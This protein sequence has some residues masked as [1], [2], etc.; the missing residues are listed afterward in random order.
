VLLTGLGAQREHHARS[1][2]LHLRRVP[3]LGRPRR[4]SSIHSSQPLS[5]DG[6]LR[7][8]VGGSE[9]SDLARRHGSGGWHWHIQ[10]DDRCESK[11]TGRDWTGNAS[12]TRGGR[13]TCRTTLT[14]LTFSGALATTERSPVSRCCTNMVT[15]SSRSTGCGVFRSVSPVRHGT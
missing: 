11:C 2:L 9:R 8:S 7:G 12:P 1:S 13:R 10:S 5:Q 6:N 15:K 14:A 4:H 3:P